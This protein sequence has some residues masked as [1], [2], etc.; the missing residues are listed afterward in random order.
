MEVKAPIQ[1]DLAGSRSGMS[2]APRQA[3]RATLPVQV[4]FRCKVNRANF[5]QI[6]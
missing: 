1:R 6:F 2:S 5:K 4:R 3:S